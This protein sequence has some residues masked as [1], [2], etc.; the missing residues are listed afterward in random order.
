MTWTP[1]ALREFEEG[2][3]GEYEA[4]VLLGAAKG[5]LHLSRGNEAQLIEIFQDVRPADWKFCTYRAHYHALLSEVDPAALRA[6]ILAG[7]SI[8]LQFPEKRFFTSSIVGGCLP[9][10]VGVAAGICRHG[11]DERVWC[12]VGD[13]A[14]SIGAFHD[15]QRF[16]SG[17]DLPVTFVVEDNGMSCTTPTEEVWGSVIALKTLRYKYEREWPHSGFRL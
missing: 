4:R 17:H 16:A 5:A 15:A 14:A 7:Q 13:M 10:A 11:G 2:I 1:E 9:I 12:F 6:E 3:R 8:S